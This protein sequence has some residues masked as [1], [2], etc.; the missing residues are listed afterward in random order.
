ML[1]PPLVPHRPLDVVDFYAVVSVPATDAAA[2]RQ[3]YEGAFLFLDFE[4]P[5]S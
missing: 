5:C 3:N 1:S 2:K 4:R